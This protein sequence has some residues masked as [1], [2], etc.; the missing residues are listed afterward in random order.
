MEPLTPSELRALY[1]LARFETAVEAAEFTHLSPQTIRN[2]SYRAF[3]KLGV[4]GRLEAFRKLGW[5]RPPR[6][7]PNPEDAEMRFIEGSERPSATDPFESLGGD[8]NVTV[9]ARH[10][11]EQLARPNI[12]IFYRQRE[13]AE[14]SER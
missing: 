1:I 11:A 13:E 9:L 14:R 2:Q 6:F 12:E 4:N 3:K 8:P 10:Q 7:M 5:L